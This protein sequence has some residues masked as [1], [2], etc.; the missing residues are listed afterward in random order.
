[1]SDYYDGFRDRLVGDYHSRNARVVAALEFAT[2]NLSGRVLDVGCGIGWSSFEL[3]EAGCDV[4]GV[5]FSPVLVETARA[6][7]PHIRFVCADFAADGIGGRFDG[8]LMMDVYEHFPRDA[9]SAVHDRI[10][11]LLS[12]PLVM[13]VPTVAAMQY[14]RDHQIPLQ[15]VDEDVTDED[16]HRLVADVAGTVVVNREVTVWQPGDY[17]HLRIDV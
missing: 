9:R 14:A 4:T 3:A 5:D 15:P 13:T 1:M 10:C 11:R 2:N 6:M 17:R 12:G 16:I 8:L 7:F